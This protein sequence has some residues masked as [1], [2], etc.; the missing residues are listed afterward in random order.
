MWEV[1]RAAI[2]A[3]YS[4][5]KQLNQ[6]VNFIQADNSKLEGEDWGDAGAAAGWDNYFSDVQLIYS[7]AN[8]FTIVNAPYCTEWL[9]KMNMEQNIKQTL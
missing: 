4:M 8:H 2:S 3:V 5:D 6:T 1:F 7:Q 9:T